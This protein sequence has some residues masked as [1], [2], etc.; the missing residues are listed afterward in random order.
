[1]VRASSVVT[2]VEGDV[3]VE[4][5]LEEVPTVVEAPVD[6]LSGPQAS[7]DTAE[8]LQPTP[9]AIV[10]SSDSKR[11]TL[12]VASGPVGPAVDR[13]VEE[14]TRPS[15]PS[16][17][18]TS[19]S[20]QLSVPSMLADTTFHHIARVA[21]EILDHLK[22]TGRPYDLRTTLDGI[23]YGL[24]VTDPA[25]VFMVRLIVGGGP[26]VTGMGAGGACGEADG[27]SEESSFS[28]RRLALE[29]RPDV[30]S[31]PLCVFLRLTVLLLRPVCAGPAQA[32]SATCWSVGRSAFVGVYCGSSAERSC[33]L[34]SLRAS[35]PR[36]EGGGC[37]D[38]VGYGGGWCDG[39]GGRVGGTGGS[40][41]A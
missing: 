37:R 4:S 21:I 27:G 22:L 15:D 29:A 36:D 35:R 23:M 2:Q 32:C 26:G 38:E 7:M 41:Q 33:I 19:Q 31:A 5:V 8:V 14:T 24:D 25:V 28:C 12:P 1:M 39:R 3:A 20:V 9:A 13:C 34:C 18:L 10:P 16:S 17:R 6:L 30:H 40:G 11:G